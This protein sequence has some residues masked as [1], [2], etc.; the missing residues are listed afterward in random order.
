MDLDLPH[1]EQP[2]LGVSTPPEGVVGTAAAVRAGEVSAVEVITVALDRAKAGQDTLNAFTYIDGERAL[3]AASDLDA[4]IAKDDEVGSLAG[5]PVGV[6]DLIDHAD[7]PNTRGS[8]FEA[9]VPTT[10]ATCIARMEAAG[11]VVIGRTGLHEFAYGFS[12]ENHWFGTIQNPWDTTL[13]P[14]GSSGGSAA[15]V[16]AGL[17]PA[18]LGTDTGGS[19][20][21]PAALCGIVG[22]K[23]THG[24]VPLSGVYP[25]ASSVDTVGPLSRTVV[26]VVAVYE[27]IAGDDATDP[28]SVP[29]PV[30]PVGAAADLTQVRVGVPQPWVDQSLDAAQET[31]FATAIERL[32]ELGAEVVHLDVPDLAASEMAAKALSFEI[33]V[34]HRKRL[35]KYPERYG[36]E[37]RERL[38]AA[39]KVT[40]EDFIEALAWRRGLRAVADRAFTQVDVLITPTV[41]ARR[42]QI[43]QDTV[44]LAGSEVHYRGPLSIF[45]SV[46]NHLG[47]PALAVPLPGEDVPPPS[48]QII[49]PAWSESRL[50]EI[51]LAL[52]A[53]GISAVAT[54][55]TWRP[56]QTT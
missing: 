15:A 39:L 44:E 49:G 36:P 46:V 29:K 19:V 24:R 41:A 4:R 42:K 52:E 45:T 1:Y 12:S 5:V 8:G 26:D 27:V 16:A 50:L 56:G 37:T 43:G 13:S 9:V 23:V 3:A 30:T 53:S 38:E 47:L 18:A 17:V 11:A 6:K 55:P 34:L 54:P 35:E 32:A 33:A 2:H 21:V 14:G 7:R 51:G 25:L 31:G 22:L 28:W 40:A 20:R 10:T 48:L